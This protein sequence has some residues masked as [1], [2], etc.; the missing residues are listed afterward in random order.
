M[1]RPKRDIKGKQ[2]YERIEDAFWYLLSKMPYNKITIAGLRANA[3]VNHNLIYYY[4]ENIDDMALRLFEK[5]MEGEF[6]TYLLSVLMDGKA[7][8]SCV[9]ENAELMKR[10][11]RTRLFMKSESAYLNKLVKERLQKEW[12]KAVGVSDN[13]LTNENMIDLEF[14]FSGIIAVI[15]SNAFD[16]DFQAIATLYQRTL[17]QGV[18]QTLKEFSTL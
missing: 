3:Q 2:A 4:F 16:K 9:A 11:G 14:I 12:L 13:Q 1:A 15:G 6:P 5:N 8:Y 18:V 7:D 17:G 10:I